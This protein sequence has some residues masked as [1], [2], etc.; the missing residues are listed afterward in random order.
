[1]LQATVGSAAPPGPPQ[2]PPPQM[3]TYQAPPLHSTPS[4]LPPQMSVPPPGPSMYQ[5]PPHMAPQHA[6]YRPPPQPAPAAQAPPSSV[7]DLNID[8]AQRV[9]GSP[10]IVCYGTLTLTCASPQQML[11]QVLSLTQDQINGLPPTEREAIQALVRSHE[12]FIRSYS[13]QSDH[14]EINLWAGSP[15]KK[16]CLGLLLTAS[17]GL[18]LLPFWV[19][20]FRSVTNKLFFSR[21][22]V[23]QSKLL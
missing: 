2:P 21:L 5:Q 8:P 14:S 10:L 4:V 3:P 19:S 18:G 9:S 17:G 12:L 13:R 23:Y 22:T 1:M 7:P 20:A 15:H 16:K 6:Y 11:L